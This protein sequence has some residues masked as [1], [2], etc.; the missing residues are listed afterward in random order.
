MLPSLCPEDYVADSELDK[1]E[2]DFQEDAVTL[3]HMEKRV[4][5]VL[6]RHPNGVNRYLMSKRLGVGLN[7]AQRYLDKLVKDNKIVRVGREFWRGGRISPLYF[8]AG[9]A[10]PQRLIRTEYYKSIW[11]AYFV[12]HKS[13][14]RIQQETGHN[15]YTILRAIEAAPPDL[16]ASLV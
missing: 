6:R 11:E 9:A 10:I 5:S 15:Y 8:I 2:R 7:E 16:A 12:E 14:H 4:L 13:R 1:P 3:R